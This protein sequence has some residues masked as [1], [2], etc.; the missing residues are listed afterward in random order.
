MAIIAALMAVATPTGVNALAQA[1]ATA[2]AANFRTLQ[3]AV[4][5]MLMFEKT[6]PTSGEILDYIYANG[7][8]S[9]KPEGFSISYSDSDK[10][11]VIK[12]T[13]SDIDAVKVKNINNSVELDTDNKMI[14]KVPR[15]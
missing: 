14:I 11:Y 3:Q 6:P 9:T 13:N 1:K 7:Y 4:I 5:Q 8:I 10:M 12:Y 15:S 2:V